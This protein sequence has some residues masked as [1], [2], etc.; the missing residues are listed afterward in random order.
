[1]VYRDNVNYGTLEPEYHQENLGPLTLKGKKYAL[2]SGL[3]EKMHSV[4]N[5]LQKYE[6]RQKSLL[7]K[8]KDLNAKD[9]KDMQKCKEI[10]V[11]LKRIIDNQVQQFNLKIK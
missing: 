5:E 4:Q 11:N 8:G 1:M 7:E 3:T 6:Q 2:V 10:V 9:M